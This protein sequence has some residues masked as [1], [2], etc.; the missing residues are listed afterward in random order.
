MSRGPEIRSAA[1]RCLASLKTAGRRLL[2]WS[3][4]LLAAC[5]G[6]G[7]RVE[8]AYVVDHA[9]ASPRV[10]FYRYDERRMIEVRYT[11]GGTLNEEYWLVDPAR[12]IDVPLTH[13]APSTCTRFGGTAWRTMFN[14][15]RTG[16][17][18]S[19]ALRPHYASDDPDVLVFSQ[20]PEEFFWPKTTESDDEGAVATRFD[21]LV[22][23]DG[24]RHFASHQ[25]LLHPPPTRPSRQGDGPQYADYSDIPVRVDQFSKVHFIVVRAGVAYVGLGDVDAMP[26]APPGSIV[27]HLEQR[28]AVFAFDPRDTRRL[29]RARLV[30]GA[31]LRN[32]ALPIFDAATHRTDEALLER[33]RPPGSVA[34][35]EADRRRYVNALRAE[36]PAWAAQQNID[37]GRQR[38]ATSSERTKA[39]EAASKRGDPCAGWGPY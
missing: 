11:Q 2:P 28:I 13:Q 21:I 29:P 12:G 7:Y 18:P 33:A 9:I 17:T 26:S 38:Y 31:E 25:V 37:I 24:G 20:A 15:F 8:L 39:V 5:S 16:S 34:Y 32:F 27:R 22:S 19:V 6:V 4:L 14:H 23:L 10:P 3:L 30:H 1:V 36:F 35:D